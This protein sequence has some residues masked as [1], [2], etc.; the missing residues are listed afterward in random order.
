MLITNKYENILVVSMLKII[1]GEMPCTNRKN[2]IIFF[3]TKTRIDSYIHIYRVCENI[4]FKTM[5]LKHLNLKHFRH[6]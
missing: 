3:F 2:N 6:I 4:L 1:L 5:N